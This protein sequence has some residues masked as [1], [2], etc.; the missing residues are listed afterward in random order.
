LDFAGNVTF[1]GRE[2]LGSNPTATAAST[3][4]T[5]SARGTAFFCS[6]SSFFA[7]FL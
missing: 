4:S 1:F 7:A 5:H 6:A 2:A 3:T